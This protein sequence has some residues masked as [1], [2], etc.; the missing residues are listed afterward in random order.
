MKPYILL[1]LLLWGSSLL[2]AQSHTWTYPVGDYLMHLQIDTTYQTSENGIQKPSGFKVARLDVLSRQ[3]QR[4]IQSLHP[5]QAGSIWNWGYRFDN[6]LTVFDANFDGYPDVRLKNFNGSYWNSATWY[7]FDP[8]AELFVH[9]TVLS[10]ANG[11]NFDLFTHT[12]HHSWRLGLGEFGHETYLWEDGQWVLIAN[13]NDLDT[14]GGM[15]EYV[16]TLL[17][18]EGDE[19]H[20][21]PEHAQ[22]AC[23][24]LPPGYDCSLLQ[25]AVDANPDLLPS[26][27]NGPGPSIRGNHSLTKAGHSFYVKCDTHLINPDINGKPLYYFDIDR[28]DVY[29][30]ES[31]DHIQSFRPIEG[32][33]L[34]TNYYTPQSLITVKDYNYDL[35]PDLRIPNSEMMYLTTYSF[36]LWHPESN[37]YQYDSTLS[38][39]YSPEFDAKTRTV[40]HTWHVGVNFFAHEVYELEGSQWVLLARETEMYMDAEELEGSLRVRVNGEMKDFHEEA[41]GGCHH[42]SRGCNLLERAREIQE[43]GSK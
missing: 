26:L 38:N 34:N 41:E 37:S 25:R 27:Y 10:Y 9:D 18:R 2:P 22:G 42:V 30:D 15:V 33:G 5:E 16:T 6:A 19:M 40:H 12:F 31:S 36:Y 29:D 7:L 28:I 3:D 14:L 23:Y 24:D 17:V 43:R 21:F 11:P 32:D 39:T 20:E 4:Y 1:F 13:E 35:H 8:K